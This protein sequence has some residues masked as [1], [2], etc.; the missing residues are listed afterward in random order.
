MI[1]VLYTKAVITQ[2]NHEPRKLIRQQELIL[3]ISATKSQAK[4]KVRTGTRTASTIKSI[5]HNTNAKP[6]FSNF[7]TS[8]TITPAALKTPTINA[9]DA[10]TIDPRKGTNTAVKANGN[11]T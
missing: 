1:Y 3:L 7:K 11:K 5:N 8:I 4:R 10:R 6:K 9:I 2:G